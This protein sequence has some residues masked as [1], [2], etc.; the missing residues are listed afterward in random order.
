MCDSLEQIQDSQLRRLSV[1]LGR[2]SPVVHLQISLRSKF[3]MVFKMFFAAVLVC[4]FSPSLVSAR[5]PTF[6]DHLQQ[7]KNTTTRNL[8]I[9]GSGSESFDIEFDSTTTCGLMMDWDVY[10]GSGNEYFDDHCSS[11]KITV[12][13]DPNSDLQIQTSTSSEYLNFVKINVDQTALSTHLYGFSTDTAG[14]F[15]LDNTG[16]SGTGKYMRW[17]AANGVGSVRIFRWN[18]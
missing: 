7:M 3:K 13:V 8:P 16:A 5:L 2:H 4:I 9:S 10:T 14:V 18:K 11:K 1:L 12:H 6:E 15:D 17:I